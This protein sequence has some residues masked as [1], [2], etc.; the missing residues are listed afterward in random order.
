MSGPVEPCAQGSDAEEFFRRFSNLL[1]PGPAR[2]VLVRFFDATAAAAVISE[3]LRRRGASS[4]LVLHPPDSA[5][6][7][8]RTPIGPS[9]AFRIVPGLGHPGSIQLASLLSRHCGGLVVASPRDPMLRALWLP[10]GILEGFSE[11]P[12][13]SDGVLVLED[14]H[15]LVDG[16]LGATEDPSSRELDERELDEVLVEMFR[17]LCDMHLVVATTKNSSTLESAA[18][19][20]VM[21]GP[22]V[23][24][25]PDFGVRIV[26]DPLEEPPAR[27][28]QLRMA[29][30]RSLL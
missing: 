8:Y 11:L 9:G 15:A 30:E 25:R 14:W 21:V 17:A 24:E 13:S 28:Y 23:G 4:R 26:R 16:Y 5:P 1:G 20:I 7:P 3:A 29:S 10:P 27:S 22:R 12:P 19:A 2:L 6:A 18:D